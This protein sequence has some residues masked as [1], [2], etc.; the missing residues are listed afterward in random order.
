VRFGQ[1]S[2]AESGEGGNPLPPPWEEI[3]EPV[4]LDEGIQ[5]KP[6]YPVDQTGG[7]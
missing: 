1:G 5:P 7:W 2:D 3:V 6:E 4:F